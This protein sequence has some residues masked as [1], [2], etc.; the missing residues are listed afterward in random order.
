MTPSALSDLITGALGELVDEGALQ[1]DGGVPAGVR[2]ERPRRAEHGDYAT[3]VALR[4]GGRAGLAPRRLAGLLASRL[5]ECDAVA[6]VEVAGP[7]FL[8]VRLAARAQGSVAA[9]VVAAGPSYGCADL[10]LPVDV[11]GARALRTPP[12]AGTV[13][14]PEDLVARLGADTARYALLRCPPGTALDIDE[15]RWARQTDD[16]PLFHVQYAHARA[17]SILRNATDLGL[18]PARGDDFDPAML[19]QPE[20]GSLLRALAEMPRVV[21]SAAAQATPHRV[22]RYLE[23]TASAFYRFHDACRV[24]PVG[25]QEPSSLHAARR[26]LVEASRIVLANGLGLLGVSAPLRL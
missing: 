4:L 12:R 23:D 16:N 26:L 3:S 24:L 5:A 9:D 22:A 15:D 6:S 7:G 21:A 8:N 25:E 18:G 13:G 17:A 10:L 19:D 20:E 11:L 14:P 2:V 1:L